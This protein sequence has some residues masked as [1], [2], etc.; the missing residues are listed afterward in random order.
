MTTPNEI[1]YERELIRRGR[2]KTIKELEEKSKSTLADNKW[3][4]DSAEPLPF[5]ESLRRQ[6][7][8]HLKVSSN[9][10]TSQDAMIDA[11]IDYLN[12]NGA[13]ISATTIK[14]IVDSYAHQTTAVCS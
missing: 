6:Q 14:V 2:Q 13:H 4:L 5:A 8:E 9:E 1:E 11:L 3:T 12:P 7:K 10:R